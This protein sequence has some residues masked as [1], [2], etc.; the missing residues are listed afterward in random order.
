MGIPTSIAPVLR[1]LSK[2]KV[3]HFLRA[4]AGSMKCI[5]RASGDDAPIVPSPRA[6]RG[7]EMSM[8][9]VIQDYC[10]KDP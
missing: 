5:Q 1:Q 3:K 7:F 6:S 10:E 4:S 2:E 8:F 9:P